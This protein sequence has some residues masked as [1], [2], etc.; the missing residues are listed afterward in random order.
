MTRISEKNS[1]QK[2]FTDAD[3]DAAVCLTTEIRSALVKKYVRGNTDLIP[4]L[5]P[6]RLSYLLG[7]GRKSRVLWSV[8]IMI[9]WMQAGLEE[10]LNTL[11]TLPRY[12][13]FLTSFQ[14]IFFSNNSLDILFFDIVSRRFQEHPLGRDKV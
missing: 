8:G 12:S 2:L 1:L 7:F 5:T 11:P 3:V 10:E 14:S 6:S 4:T 13:H 9:L